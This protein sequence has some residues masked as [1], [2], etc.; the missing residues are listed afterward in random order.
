M[1]LTDGQR[2]I[3]AM[4]QVLGKD[5]LYGVPPPSNPYHIWFFSQ[6]LPVHG[7]GNRRVTTVTAK[8]TLTCSEKQKLN[9][10]RLR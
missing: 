2:F 3:N 4:R 6:T 5:P 10:S 9:R 1:A 7:E 8:T